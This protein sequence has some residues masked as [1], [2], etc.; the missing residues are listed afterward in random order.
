VAHAEKIRCDATPVRGEAIDRPTPL[1]TIERET[2]QEQ[3]SPARAAFDVGN[4]AKGVRANLRNALKLAAR[5][6]SASPATA[7]S[8]AGIA[9]AVNART[10]NICVASRNPLRFMA[11]LPCC[12]PTGRQYSGPEARAGGC[13][14]L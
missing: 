6:G 2:M 14:I 12:T 5:M 8:A 4:F 3:C 13:R 1:E 11:V 9:R 10:P 7:A